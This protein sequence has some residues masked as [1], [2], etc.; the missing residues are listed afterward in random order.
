M[1]L[2]FLY[3]ATFC[4]TNKNTW[5]YWDSYAEKEKNPMFTNKDIVMEIKYRLAGYHTLA[6]QKL[7]NTRL[8]CD[9]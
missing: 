8:F 4:K 7:T 2:M 6:T 1:N 3:S 9:K 5:E